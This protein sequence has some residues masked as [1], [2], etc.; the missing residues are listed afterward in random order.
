MTNDI[1][2]AEEAAR[3]VRVVLMAK[4][5]G[6]RPVGE[7]ISEEACK[8]AGNVLRDQGIQD[9]MVLAAMLN[10]QFREKI[11]A[12]ILGKTYQAAQE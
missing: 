6:K 12:E 10:K 11:S 7:D 8:I 3:A 5:I 1:K 2:L 9:G 4:L